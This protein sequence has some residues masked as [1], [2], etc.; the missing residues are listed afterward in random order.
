MRLADVEGGRRSS[1]RG[2]YEN[3][4]ASCRSRPQAQPDEEGVDPVP[5]GEPPDD[6]LPDDPLPDAPPLDDPLPDDPP[7]DEAVEPDLSDDV[8]LDDELLSPDVVPASPLPRFS[9]EPADEPEPLA[10][11]LPE[12]LSVR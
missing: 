11:L 3:G 10:A 1:T 12:R 8:A 7:L 6:P 5:P 2:R 4:G 9:D